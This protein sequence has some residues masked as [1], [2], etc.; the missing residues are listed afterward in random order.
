MGTNAQPAWTNKLGID[1]KTTFA[2]PT[3]ETFFKRTE[4]PRSS[5]A[6]KVVGKI[7]RADVGH[8]LLLQLPATVSNRIAKAINGASGPGLVALIEY[9]LDQLDNNSLTIIVE[10]RD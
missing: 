10:N 1:D 3:E 5:S 2:K 7:R 8:Q 6:V 9:A 4:M